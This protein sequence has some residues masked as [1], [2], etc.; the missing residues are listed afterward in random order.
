M[1][2]A[3]HSALAPDVAP[4]V[5]FKHHW[6]HFIRYYA[7]NKPLGHKSKPIEQTHLVLHLN[8]ILKLLLQEQT[9]LA[10]AAA[11]P[12][13]DN[14]AAILGPCMEYL[15]N[16]QMLDILSS[17]CQADSPPG[18]RPYLFNF[19]IFMLTRQATRNGSSVVPF[20]FINWSNFLLA[21]STRRFF[22]T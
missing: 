3:L 19:F 20:F 13:A 15:I 22:P 17:L 21:G 7:E 5:D 8:H 18:I 2:A 12:N 9:E 16:R 10:A 4:I 11:S 6:S 14:A 1:L